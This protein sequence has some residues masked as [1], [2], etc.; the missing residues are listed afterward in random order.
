MFVRLVGSLTG[1]L[2][3]ARCSLAKVVW[4]GEISIYRLHPSLTD[5]D[6]GNECF[7]EISITKILS[8]PLLVEL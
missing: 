1:S 6:L 2:N 3:I 7:W 4:N 5:F 8:Q